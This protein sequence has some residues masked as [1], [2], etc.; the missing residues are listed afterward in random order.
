MLAFERSQ[1]AVRIAK[2]VRWECVH[3]LSDSSNQ[4]VNNLHIR[5]SQDDLNEQVTG[6]YKP[7][8]L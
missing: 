1:A 8:S 2:Q 7:G 4:A 5:S 3:I 6:V